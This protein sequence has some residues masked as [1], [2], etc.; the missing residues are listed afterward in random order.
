MS[1]FE[2][3]YKD[4]VTLFTTSVKANPGRPLFG[5]KKDGNWEWIT[6]AQFGEMVD[7]CRAGLALLGVKKGDRVAVI[8]NNRV[9]WAAAA[10]ATYGLGAAYVPMYEAQQPK[11]WK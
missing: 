7:K 6:Y 5:T 11:E 9:E 10:Y 8:S 1:T 2:P 4:L 3:R